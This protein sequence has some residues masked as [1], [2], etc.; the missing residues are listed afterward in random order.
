MKKPFL[1]AVALLCG[2]VWVAQA[3]TQITYVTVEY[4]EQGTIKT[5]DF[6]LEGGLVQILNNSVMIVFAE[7]PALNRTYVFDDINTMNFERRTVNAIEN[8]DAE[9]FKVHFDGNIL[10]INAAQ[11]IGKVNVY[12]ITGARVAEVESA[13]H[14]A[15][16]NLSALPKGTYIVQTGTNSVKI[17]K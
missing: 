15:Q 5:D 16:M 6:S 9:T 7:N 13:A 17:I 11:S 1:F 10:H 14:T 12:S 8:A 3:Q 2:A 4:T